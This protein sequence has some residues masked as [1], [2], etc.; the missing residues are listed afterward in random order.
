MTDTLV[1][2]ED[3]RCAYRDRDSTTTSHLWP[4]KSEDHLLIPIVV[5]ELSLTIN[6]DI[7]RSRRHGRAE[8]KLSRLICFA[9]SII[10][11]PPWPP[12]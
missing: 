9:C 5:V 12:P 8:A 2:N 10:L 3:R 1:F 6:V 11:A 7:D 4:P